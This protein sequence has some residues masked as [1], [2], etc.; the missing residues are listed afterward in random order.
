MSA[1]N[2]R[3]GVAAENTWEAR[4]QRAGWDVYHPKNGPVDLI[5]FREDQQP[6]FHQVKK[7]A[8]GP[9]A[10]FPPA[11]RRRFLQAAA[12][13]GAMPLLVWWPPGK[14]RPRIFP[15]STWPPC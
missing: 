4:Q 2:R 11:D 7:T 13:A 15:A 10:G 8:R 6:Q 3:V 1:R 5:M 12:K 9:F 14:D